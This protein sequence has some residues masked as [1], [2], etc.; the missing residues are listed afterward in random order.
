MKWLLFFI[1]EALYRN[2]DPG[3]TAAD[4]TIGKEGRK[5]STDVPELLTLRWNDTIAVTGTPSYVGKS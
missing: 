2:E 3:S 1:Q 5:V 4:G